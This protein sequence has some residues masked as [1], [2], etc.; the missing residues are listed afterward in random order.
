MNSSL[1]NFNLSPNPSEIFIYSRVSSSK[2][3][4]DAHGLDYQD[5]VCENYAKEILNTKL[6]DINYYCDVGSGYNSIKKLSDL[7]LMIKN[8]IPRSVILVSEISRL[9]RNV[10]QVLPM[11][12]KIAEKNCWIISVSEGLCFNNS[13]LMDKQIYQKVI[14]AERESDLISIRT[15]NTNKLIKSNG[16]HIGSIP[17]GKERVKINGIGVL[18]DNKKETDNIGLIKNL[19]NKYKNYKQVVQ[20]LNEKQIAKRNSKWTISS[21]KSIITKGNPTINLINS[22]FNKFTVW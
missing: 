17:Y 16:G 21:V 13:K 1:V 22:K 10:Q 12:K 8:L 15:S 18:V 5:M 20:E 19:Y 9:G 4:L 6:Q 14:D 2:Q 11:L 7:N 3:N